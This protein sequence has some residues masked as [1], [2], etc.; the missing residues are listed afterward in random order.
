MSRFAA[1]LVIA[2]GCA[3]PVSFQGDRVLVVNARIAAPPAP[4]PVEPPRVEVR[5]NK[6]TIN[7]K[8]QFAYDKADILPASFGLLDE[9]AAVIMKHPHIKKIRID[10]HASSDGEATHNMKLSQSRAK[11]VMTYLVGKGIAKAMLVSQGLGIT[12]PIADNATEDGRERNRRVEF[13]IV[14]QDVTM[15]KVEIDKAGKEKVLEESKQTV[16]A[17]DTS[18]T[19]SN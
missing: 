18:K 5:D 13:H 17:Q 9:V 3:K 16:K 12:K 2:I 8:I 14:E 7:E 11:S 15:K 6:I 4:A 19:S 10:G 1:V